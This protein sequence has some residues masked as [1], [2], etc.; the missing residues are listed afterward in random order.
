MQIT[1]DKFTKRFGDVIVVEDMDLTVGQGE[2]VALLGESGCGKS[3]TLFSVCGIY[4][5]DGGRILFGD[6]DVTNLSSQ[7]RNVGVVF[8]SFAL[9]PH[10]T[11]AQ[12]I[13]FPLRVK[14]E[15]QAEIDRKVREIAALVRIENLLDR[16]P[17][18][19]SG[20]QQQRVALSRALI[21]RPAILLLD[22]P[23]ANL[24]AKLRLDMRA[25]IRRLQQETGTTAILVTHDQVEA[26]SM[27][28]R[29]AIMDRGKI[30]QYDAPRTMYDKPVNKF[31]AGFLG[32]PPI[33]FLDGKAQD[34]RFIAEASDVDLPLPS[35]LNSLNG[36][37]PIS[38]GIRAEFLDPAS[39]STVSGKISFI[40]AQGRE[41]LYYLRLKDGKV[42]R[43]ILDAT[44]DT[45]L[46]QEVSWGVNTDSML[47]F[48]DDG[49][50]L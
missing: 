12:N 3:T 1:L 4:R 42:V 8:Q 28:D 15:P 11:V 34:G 16:R 46:G 32:S 48:D 21:R 19:L 27:C 49:N 50:T 18:Q 40:E 31:V 20:G 9:Y 13:G 23:L 6:R 45:S 26:M 44:D 7:E 30:I 41:D 10:M 24:D 29:V 37:R 35:H 14:K 43:G 17:G 22:E 39:A 38:V 5:I 25:E 33:S 2:M 36:G 47:V